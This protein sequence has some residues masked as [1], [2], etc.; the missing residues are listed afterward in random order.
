[1]DLA[2]F[3]TKKAAGFMEILRLLL[4]V[5]EAAGLIDNDVIYH[6]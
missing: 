3:M 4:V 6:P 2:S 5:S 1:M